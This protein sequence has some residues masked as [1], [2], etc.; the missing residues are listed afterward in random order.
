MMKVA[1]V[2]LSEESD[3]IMFMVHSSELMPA[4]SP[5][6]RN[7]ADIEQMYTEVEEVFQY[8]ADNDVEPATC[9]E[10]YW[11]FTSQADTQT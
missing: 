1:K 7:E 8:L 10:Y 4:G 6:F 5:G 9:Y 3:Y 2:K 11:H